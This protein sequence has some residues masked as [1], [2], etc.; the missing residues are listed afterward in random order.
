MPLD[1]YREE[2]GLDT[3]AP[4][5]AESPQGGRAGDAKPPAGAPAD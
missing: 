4:V 5:P 1:H 3:E 2:H